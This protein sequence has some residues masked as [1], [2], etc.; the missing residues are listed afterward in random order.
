MDG[1][2]RHNS[3]LRIICNF[4]QFH[5]FH[6]VWFPV[7]WC[8]SWP[9]GCVK[10]PAERGCRNI[11]WSHR[12]FQNPACFVWELRKSSFTWGTQRMMRHPWRKLLLSLSWP[13]NPHMCMTQIQLTFQLHTLLVSLAE[14][15]NEA[16]SRSQLQQWGFLATSSS[17]Q[18]VH[19]QMTEVLSWIWRGSTHIK[20]SRSPLQFP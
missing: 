2:E 18:T 4:T 1:I 12:K 19:Q 17:S 3:C 16:G 6:C 5:W 14:I 8:G 11:S 10:D 7:L 20:A 15:V 9:K 13:E